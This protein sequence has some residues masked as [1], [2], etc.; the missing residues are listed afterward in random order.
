MLHGGLHKGRSL[1]GLEADCKNEGCGMDMGRIPTAPVNKAS[2]GLDFF[3]T[4]GLHPKEKEATK[5]KIG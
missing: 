2:K 1:A 4:I 3:K 5:A